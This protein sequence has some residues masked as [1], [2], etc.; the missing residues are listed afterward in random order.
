MI[1]KPNQQQSTKE[2]KEQ[3]TEEKKKKKQSKCK[4]NYS[5]DMMINVFLT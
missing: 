4:T 1:M 2:T 3:Q 5:M